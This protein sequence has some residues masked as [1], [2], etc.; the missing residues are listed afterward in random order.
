MDDNH[1]REFTTFSAYLDSALRNTQLLIKYE[2]W[3]A[4]FKKTTIFL[5]K[6]KDQTPVTG[7]SLSP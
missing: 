7:K 4:K 6:S 1:W 2:N 3:L 5:V